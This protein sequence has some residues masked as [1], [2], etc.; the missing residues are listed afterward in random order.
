AYLPI[1]QERLADNFHLHAGSPRNSPASNRHADKIAETRR[2]SLLAF[3]PTRAAGI[4]GF[5]SAARE[6][7]RSGR[8][9]AH[10]RSGMREKFFARHAPAS[11]TNRGCALA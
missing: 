5:V 4:R 10:D 7:H 6:K 3:P 8:T 2:R 9:R 1:P 11:A